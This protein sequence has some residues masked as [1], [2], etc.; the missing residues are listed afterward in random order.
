VTSPALSSTDLA[1]GVPYVAP[2]EDE[3]LRD[4]F[5]TETLTWKIGAYSE[6]HA[7]EVFLSNP[8]A[9]TL[10]TQDQRSI[11]PIEPQIVRAA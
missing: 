9:G 6:E 2:E 11:T 5:I 3:P 10:Y 8:D 4:F 1:P 7:L